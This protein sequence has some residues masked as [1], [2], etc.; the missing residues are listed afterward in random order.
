MIGFG[1]DL[2]RLLFWYPLRWVIPLLP[3]RVVYFLGD[4]SGR[5]YFKVS[6]PLRQAMDEGLGL[7]FNGKYSDGRRK[8]ISRRTFILMAKTQL[9]V[10]LFGSLTK[11]KIVRMMSIDGL[12][13]IDQA[14][15]MGNGV[16]LL[17][18]HF[19]ANKLVMPALGFRGYKINQV[20]GKPTEW[21]RIMGGELSYLSRKVF[22]LEHA[23]DQ[24]LPANLIYVFKSMKP[25]I[26][27]LKN[28]EIVCM[29]ID[30]GGG[31][32]KEK[33]RFLGRDA[34]ISNGPFRIAEKCDST[35]LP[36]FV[37]RKSDNSHSMIIEDPISPRKRADE[38]TP[39]TSQLKEFLN[40]I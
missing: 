10:L 37:V 27:C 11:E 16:I 4:V 12:E 19:G 26:Q 28:D 5:I 32:K 22:E 8:F 34:M 9:E 35:I 17:I 23:N 24:F 25:V 2:V 40:F 30:G 38:S 14:R 1:K 31:T 33:V 21:I 6:G 7:I 39:G 15:S 13:K 36:A 20:A 3:L 29:A 18:A